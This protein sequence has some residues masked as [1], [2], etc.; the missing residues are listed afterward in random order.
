MRKGMSTALGMEWC[1]RKQGHQSI[2]RGRIGGW[3]GC[4]GVVQAVGSSIVPW[5]GLVECGLKEQGWEG[6]GGFWAGFNYS[7]Y[8][9]ERLSSLLKLLYEGEVGLKLGLLAVVRATCLNRFDTN[10]TRFL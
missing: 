1:G 8:R 6:W 10:R 7:C 5:A 2:E 9:L 3:K 4:R